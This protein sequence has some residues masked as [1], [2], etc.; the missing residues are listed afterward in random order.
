[1]RE[2]VN[3]LKVKIIKT[4]NFHERDIRFNQMLKATR[5]VTKCKIL[6][7][8]VT[9]GELEQNIKFNKSSMREAISSLIGQANR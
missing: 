7:P 6:N 8:Q 3:K 5:F 4:V 1:M 9:A 2:T